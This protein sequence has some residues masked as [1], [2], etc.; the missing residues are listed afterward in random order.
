MKQAFVSMLELQDKMNSK[1]H[2]Q[3]QQQGYA[4]YRA[5]WTECAEL[6]DHHG[7][8]W[9]K[10][11]TPDSHQIKLEIVDIWHF[12]LSILLTSGKTAEELAEELASHWQSADT[13]QDFLVA[14]EQLAQ[15]TLTSKG[16][17]VPLFCQLMELCNFPLVELY[18]QYIGK[19]V[20]NFFRQ[21]H[22][23]KEGTYHKVWHGKEDNEHLAEI[24]ANLDGTQADL[25]TTVYTQLQVRYP[26]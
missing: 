6:M 18:Q 15:H 8:K 10:K 26:L 16:F 25:Q 13:T 1:V 12:G 3:W 9:W 4:W 21:D 17:S 23:Y 14:V 2:P 11:Q 24:L 22:G 20:L 19:N 7:W 5:I